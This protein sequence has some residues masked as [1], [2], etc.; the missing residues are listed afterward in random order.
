MI[1]PMME[2][3]IKKYGTTLTYCGCPDYNYRQRKIQGSCKHMI[4][5]QKNKETT[6]EAKTAE[7][8]FN[9]DDFRINGMDI[10]DACERYGDKMID[11]WIKT[12]RLCKINNRVRLLE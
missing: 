8:K 1:Y 6:L 9:P 3:K 4:Y 5:K 10:H 7:A 11:E 12:G 2:I